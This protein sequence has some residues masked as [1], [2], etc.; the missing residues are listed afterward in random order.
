MNLPVYIMWLLDA[1]LPSQFTFLFPSNLEEKD[2]D[3]VSQQLLISYSIFHQ[4]LYSA[5]DTGN[6]HV[7]QGSPVDVWSAEIYKKTHF[8]HELGNKLGFDVED[9]VVLVVGSSFYNELSPEYAVA[10]NRM[11]PV[12]TKLPRKNPEVSFKFV[13]LCGNSTNRCNDALQ[14]VFSFLYVPIF[15]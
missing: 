14:V 3:F 4:M 10:L 1:W 8:K 13:F 5:L 12:L 15:L 2:T 9:I 11:G 6:F 7:I